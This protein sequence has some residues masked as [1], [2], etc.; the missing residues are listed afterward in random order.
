LKF[1][2]SDPSCAID[3]LSVLE[4]QSDRQ[5]LSH[6]LVDFKIQFW[7]VGLQEEQFNTFRML[8]NPVPLKDSYGEPLKLSRMRNIFGFEI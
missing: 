3:L 6:N 5:L 8:F 7:R 1:P 2:Y 4:L